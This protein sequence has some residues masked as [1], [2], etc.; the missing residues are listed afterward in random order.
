MAAGSPLQAQALRRRP[1]RGRHHPCIEA[2]V[3]PLHAVLPSETVIARVAELPVSV[4]K[5]AGRFAAQNA[6]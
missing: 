4:R 1:H 3:Q 6:A 2:E 5:I